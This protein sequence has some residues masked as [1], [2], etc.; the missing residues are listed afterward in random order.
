MYA[1]VYTQCMLFVGTV[2]IK[3]VIRQSHWSQQLLCFALAGVQANES[4]AYLQDGGRGP[5]KGRVEQRRAGV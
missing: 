1:S 4:M 5:G 2:H 3:S